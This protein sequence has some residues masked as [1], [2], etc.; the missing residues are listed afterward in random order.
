MR[1]F[2]EKLGLVI[3]GLAVWFAVLEAGSRWIG[4][5]PYSVTVEKL[6]GGD[7]VA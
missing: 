3:L 7:R 5:R 6:G 2:A 1:S 4:A